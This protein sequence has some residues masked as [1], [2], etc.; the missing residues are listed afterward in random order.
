MWIV[1][2]L[3]AKKLDVSI[4][5]LNDFEVHDDY[6]KNKLSGY[7]C[8]KPDHRYGMLAITKVNNWDCLQFIYATPKLDYPFD[9]VGTYKWPKCKSI[10]FYEK[11]DGTNITSYFY[12]YKDKEFLTFKTRLT[13]VVKSGGFYDFKR[14]LDD[15]LS[16]NKWVEEV[17]Y[18][19]KD[20]NLSFELFGYRNPITVKYPFPLEMNLL[21]GIDKNNANIKPIHKLKTNDNTKTPKQFLMINNEIYDNELTSTYNNFRHQMSDKNKNELLTEGMVLYANIND[22]EN[23]S[24]WKMFK[25][26]PEE[27]EKIHWAAGEGIPTVA[28][29]TTAINTFESNENPTIEDFI[30]LLKEEYD[31]HVITK[32]TAKINKIWEKTL[33]N[34]K[35]INEVNKVW[36]IA[37]DKGF[38]ITID[39]ANTMKFI[40]QY[41][42]KKSMRM[43]ASIILKQIKQ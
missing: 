12:K 1:K 18:L 24:I 19:N 27:I 39:K 4:S 34:V 3:I 6:N 16:E 32:N 7:I 2:E 29:S 43:V 38:D 21:F 22:E 20:Y 9:R 35:N 37:K 30:E 31:E 42:D 25:C 17:I 28:L 41:F 26:K 13:P 10:V 5:R 33:I 15:Y 11:L 40:S 8:L 14:L 23:N 36:Q